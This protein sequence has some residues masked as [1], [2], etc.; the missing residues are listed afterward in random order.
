LCTTWWVER[1]SCLK[2]VGELYGHVATHL[3]AIVNPR[4]YLEVN[5]SRW[6]SDSDT[7]TTVYGLKSSLQGFGVIVDFTV[8]KNSLDYL[9]GLSAKLH[10]RDIDVFE[11]YTMTNNI[12]SEIQC[13]RDD[14]GVEFQRWYDEAKQLASYIVT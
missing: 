14:I 3:D 1:L 9:K 4:V 6:N 13:L 7:M 11:A 12:N 10:R 5:E 8:S 2:T